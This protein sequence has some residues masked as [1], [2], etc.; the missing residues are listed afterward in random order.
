G[1]FVLLVIMA[2]W[3]KPWARNSAP[4]VGTQW[5]QLT[6]F[7]SVSQPALSPDGHLLAFIRGPDTFIAAGQIYVKLLPNGEAKQLTDDNT[8]KMGVA[9]SPDGSQITYTALDDKFSWN[10]YSVPVLGGAPQIMLPNAAGLTWISNHQLLFSEIK[11]G[12]NMGIVTADDSRMHE[13]EIYLPPT[14]RGMAHR[15]AL[16]PDGHSVLVVE[17]DNAG[18]Q[19]CRLVPF[20][21][22]DAGRLVGPLDSQCTNVAWSPDGKWMYFSAAKL[23]GFHLWRQNVLGGEPQQITFGPTEQEGIAVDPN[24]KF[25]I[26][27][28]GTKQSELWLHDEKGERQISSE[29]F[30]AGY[31]FSSDGK[32]LFYMVLDYTVGA[33][34]FISGTL[35]SADL[36]TGV[37][38]QVLPGV[39]MSE[40]D[41]THDGKQVVFA[42]YDEQRKPHLWMA[43]LDRSAPPRQ[44]FAEEA[45]Q[46]R[47]TDS[48][49][50]Y[51]R[52]RKDNINH[53]FRYKADGTREE[54]GNVLVNELDGVSPNGKWV[55]AWTQDPADPNHSGN[56]AINTQDG[57]FVRPCQACGIYWSPDGHYLVVFSDPLDRTTSTVVRDQTQTL[58]ISLKPGEDLPK[59]PAGGWQSAADFKGYKVQQFSGIAIPSPG[60]HGYVYPKRTAH[61]NLFRIPL[62]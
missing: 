27:A 62:G 29:G 21:G 18:W 28:A 15:S 16:S 13:R 5:E 37:I 44:L 24:G 34:G 48:G 10:T 7:D 50:I 42:A 38:T 47:L 40:Y 36:K 26:T 32:Q 52:A 51:Y 54:V 22:S 9:F 59:I 12:I 6:D 8:Q 33:Q 2:L 30:A 19:P 20:K 31:T 14:A 56:F 3:W 60:G 11:S 41:L 25:L 45:D 61:R 1:A 58:V 55:T 39:A 53:L 46:P 35:R 43:P 49:V 57:S 17:M 23:G 4:P